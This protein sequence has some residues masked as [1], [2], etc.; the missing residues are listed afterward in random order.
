MLTISQKSFI[1]RGRLVCETWYKIVNDRMGVLR[2]GKTGIS[3]LEIG[4]KNQIFL[5]KH[6]VGISIPIDWYFSCNDSF[7]AD[8]KL[9]LHKSQVHSS[10]VMQWWACSS[11]CPL[12]CLQRWSAEVTSGLFYCCSLLRNSNMATNL[13]KFTLY[14]GSR[15]FVAWDCWMYP[16]AQIIQRTVTCW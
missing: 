3:P 16:S 13:Q 7:F 9:T 2:G 8:M 1:R 10:S 14:Y 4:I 11:L 12:V 5:E 6:E 15:R